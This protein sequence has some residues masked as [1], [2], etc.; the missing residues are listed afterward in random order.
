MQE[1]RGYLVHKVRTDAGSQRHPTE[2]RMPTKQ[3]R[4]IAMRHFFLDITCQILGATHFQRSEIDVSV[5]PRISDQL[6]SNTTTA[7]Y[8]AVT[9]GPSPSAVAKTGSEAEQRNMVMGPL[10]L[11]TVLPNSV[12]SEL[13][14]MYRRA[15]SFE[16][17]L[18][19]LWSQLRTRLLIEACNLRQS[20]VVVSQI[21]EAIVAP[22]AR[23]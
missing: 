19:V 8:C 20:G 4:I 14:G 13:R 21:R 2:L 6:T 16:P 9:A 22:Q 1:L 5:L 17:V 15:Q 23:L 12:K 7:P 3:S 18:Q 10:T 11:I